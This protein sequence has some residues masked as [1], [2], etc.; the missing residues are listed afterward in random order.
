MEFL[1]KEKLKVRIAK[2]DRSIFLFTVILLAP[3]FLWML[4]AFIAAYI[5][6]TF[7]MT[8]DYKVLVTKI[9]YYL[10]YSQYGTRPS[11]SDFQFGWYN[12]LNIGLCAGIGVLLILICYLNFFQT[13][14]T[15]MNRYGYIMCIAFVISLIFANVFGQLA[16]KNLIEEDPTKRNFFPIFYMVVE[17]SDGSY[18]YQWNE[19]GITMFAFNAF[20]IL[21]AFVMLPFWLIVG[22]KTGR[23]TKET[24]KIMMLKDEKSKL[25]LARDKAK[26]NNSKSIE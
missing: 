21:V 26:D 12:N 24:G 20:A 25:M 1:D 15:I 9:G 3:C 18:F 8:S 4:A 5:P 22:N 13:K 11:P 19:S 10:S 17:N 7:D 14:R 2:K 16:G 23:I 6:F